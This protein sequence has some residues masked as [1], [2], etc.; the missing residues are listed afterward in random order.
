MKKNLIFALA[1]VMLV[2]T[3]VSC[4]DSTRTEG[5]L[6]VCVYDGGYGQEWL[7]KIAE[8]YEKE[9]G[10]KV[11]AEVDQSVL[12]RIE[13]SLKNGGDY[14]IYMSHDINWQSFAA[15]G[16]LAPLDDLYEREV[17]GTN[18]K[19]K[20][21]LIDGALEVSKSEGQDGVER[22]YKV[23]YTQGAGG[24]VYNVDMF[25]ENGWEVPTTYD[26]LV[27]LCEQIVKDDVAVKGSLDGDSVVPF[28]WSGNERQYYW[29]YVV[30]EWWAQLAGDQA[31]EQFKS[32]KG[33]ESN[34]YKDGYE[35]YNPD[36]AYKEFMEA[37][38]MWYQ[39]IANHSEYSMSGSQ[40]KKLINQQSDFVSGKA[41]MMPYAQWALKETEE[42]AD[43]KLS[44]DIAMMKTPKATADSEDYNYL[45]GFGD[46]IIVPADSPNIE[47]AKDFICYLATYDACKTFVEETEGAFFAFDYSDVDLSS[48]EA[49]NSFV[50]S[51]HEKLSTKLFNLTSMNPMAYY[52]SNQLQPWIGNT[53]YYAQAIVKPSDYTKEKVGNSIYS[54]AKSN[55]NIWMRSAGVS[56]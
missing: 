34:K 47:L 33:P 25:E 19:F 8:D 30:F 6:Y 28:T 48:I 24:I 26:E 1:A 56:D 53:Y 17:A 27:A 29:D 43:K 9:T 42:A 18:K 5:E 44:F 15:E 20:E 50:K 32:F 55:W 49:N 3:L 40:G 46:S 45:V 35:V 12:D 23:C 22:Y 14:D 39:L 36:G 21:R 16:L 37:Y 7:D 13:G 41:A 2:G 4:N 51:V 31:I 52:T 11:H 38:D 54:Y 10:V